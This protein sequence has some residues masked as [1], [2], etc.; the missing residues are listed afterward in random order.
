MTF[1]R[2]RRQL[3][4]RQLLRLRELA[5]SLVDV[6]VGSAAHPPT[7]ALSVRQTHEKVVRVIAG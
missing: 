6:R 2:T 4:R 7:G 1:S 3:C 5:G